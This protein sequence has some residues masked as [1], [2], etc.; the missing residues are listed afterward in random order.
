VKVASGT[1]YTKVGAT[2]VASCT[3]PDSVGPRLIAMIKESKGCVGEQ[4]ALYL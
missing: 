4:V 2:T 3:E 1:I